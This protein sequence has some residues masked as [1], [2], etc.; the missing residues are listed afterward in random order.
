MLLTNKVS[1]N[2]I[3]NLVAEGIDKV[4]TSGASSH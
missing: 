3:D 2:G 4:S 1:S